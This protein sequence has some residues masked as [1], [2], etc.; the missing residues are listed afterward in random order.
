MANVASN[1]VD[2]TKLARKCRQCIFQ[3]KKPMGFSLQGEPFGGEYFT[4]SGRA[5]P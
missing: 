1:I 5:S 2:R 3:T 4:V